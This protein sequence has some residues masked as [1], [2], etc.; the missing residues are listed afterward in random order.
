M[1]SG[2]LIA[3]M[4]GLSA[5]NEPALL[6][7]YGDTSTIVVADTVLHGASFEVRFNTFAGGCVRETAGTQLAESGSDVVIRPF[8]RNSGHSACDA[9]LIYLDHVVRLKRDMA[10][11]F[12]LRIIG[13]QRPWGTGVGSG[14]AELTR[15]V[16]VK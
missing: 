2:C 1:T 3:E 13:N 9:S 5:F 4:L 16:V 11:E 8:N 15:R 6:I 7:F 12:V 14:P 10:G